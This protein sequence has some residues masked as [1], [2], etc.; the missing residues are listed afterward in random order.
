MSDVFQF[1]WDQGNSQSD[2]YIDN[3][4]FF[5]EKDT[6]GINEVSAD[7]ASTVWYDLMGRRYEQKPSAAGIYIN[8]GKKVVIK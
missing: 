2:I 3:L 4:Y 8:N 1:K 5:K 6:T 7:K